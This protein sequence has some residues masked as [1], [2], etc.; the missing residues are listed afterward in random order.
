MQ[1]IDGKAT[2]LEIQS[3]LRTAISSLHAR[4][5]R[6][7]VVLVGNFAPSVIYVTN[8]TRACSEVGITSHIHRLPDTISQ[9]ELLHVIS[10][11]NNNPEIDGILV[12]FPLPP[13]IQPNI[14]MEEISPH[15]DVDGFNPINRG[16]LFLGQEDALIP[17]TPLGVIELMRR[18]HIPTSGK[19]VTIIGRSNI[20]GK[21][22][23]VLLMLPNEYGNAT[24]TVAHSKTKNLEQACSQ[25]DILIAA[26]GQ[27]LFVGPNMVKE[28]AV[29]IDVG[30]NALGEAE[31]G[32]KRRVAGDVDF[33]AV[34]EKCSWITPV[35]GGVGPMTIAM[36]LSNTFKAYQRQNCAS[37]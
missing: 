1:L 19:N 27:P 17:C 30:M 18:Y 7:D 14:I 31:E 24:V 9:D 3:E 5:P 28:G 2:A 35:P 11:L 6:L 25:A 34:K 22:L 33:H 12:Q 23:A 26:I 8:K 29:V 37:E 4:S 21:P 16:K 32:K 15:K 36:L 10:T 13:H 20:V